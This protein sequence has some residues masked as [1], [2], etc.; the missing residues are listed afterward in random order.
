MPSQGGSGSL[1]ANFSVVNA[2]VA[3]TASPEEAAA[4]QAMLAYLLSR[5][6]TLQLFLL[7][8]YG[9]MCLLCIILVIY[10]R[11]NRNTA[12]R[13]DATA[14]RKIIL[15][16]Y[17]PLLWV[18]G[19][20]TGIYTG[21]FCSALATELYTYE[22]S[23][24]A[25]EVFYSGRQFVFLSV[26]VFMLQKSVSGPA[27]RR[28]LII[29][30]VLS[31]YTIPLVW[32]FTAYYPAAD[33][34]APLTAARALLLL[35]YSYVLVRPPVRASKRT[36][37][38]YCV[39]A[40]I[41]YTL[42]F[43]YNECF[44]QSHL[45]S[46]FYLTYSNLLCGSL[47][48]LVIWRVL[49]ADTEHWRGM[50]QRA[51][52]LQRLFCQTRG[53]PER[54]SSK[55]LHILIEMHRKFIIDFAYLE[56]QQR[57]GVGAS[58]V[59]FKGTL[60]SSIDVAV[61]V[62]TPTDFT[63]DTVA[64]FSHEAALC[65]ALHHPNIVAFHGMCVCPP[66]ICL[67]NELCVGSLEDITVAAARRRS[68]VSEHDHN[69]Q[70][71]LLNVAFMLDAARAVSYLHS[72][73]PPFL[74]RDIKPTNF[75]VDANC[76]VKLTDFGESRSLPRAQ[77]VSNGLV[78]APVTTHRSSLSGY[79]GEKVSTVAMLASEDSSAKVPTE[80]ASIEIAVVGAANLQQ[81]RGSLVDASKPTT[82][83][84]SDDNA[85]RMTVKG[86]VDYMAPEVINGRAGL[87]AYGEA[88][89]VYS[90]GITMWDVLNPGQ[91]KFPDAGSNHF[92]V[93][94]LVL[95]G[96]RPEL[97]P[98]LHPSIRAI[99]E[100]SWQHDPRLRPS[101]H[102]VVSTLESIQE[103]LSAAFALELA[104]E[105][106]DAMRLAK[107][108]DASSAPLAAPQGF[109]GEEAISHMCELQYVDS[110]SEAV[111]LGNALMDSGLLHHCKHAHP[112]EE[113]EQVYF[114]D[115]DNINL[116]Q[117]LVVGAYTQEQAKKLDAESATVISSPSRH[118]R[119]TSHRSGSTNPFANSG[120]VRSDSS[121]SQSDRTL[122]ENGVCACRKLGQRL[123][124]PK[125][126]K[127]RHRFRR[128]GKGK[129]GMKVSVVAGDAAE[130]LH[131]RLLLES[132]HDMH[133]FDGF[134][135]SPS[136]A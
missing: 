17:E 34:Y 128:K 103:E 54:V 15:P 14:A 98:R 30:L 134:D 104:D 20:T 33:L 80:R 127:S 52:A 44:R 40:Y 11:F 111:R 126:S 31:T 71:L 88:A 35:L 49:R 36:L 26:I 50:G 95:E 133:D 85:V 110:I 27:L 81:L 65:G 67:V 3:P 105:L 72:F 29:T 115:D 48:P 51:V 132:P 24:L 93:F 82:K 84:S 99:I 10:L 69:R 53:M 113:S 106:E 47:C 4:K 25:T 129:T 64:A 38:E 79:C 120:R 12:L 77:V 125:A 74:H 61:K 94:D 123:K 68:R 62:Y 121:Q 23:K 122:L 56:L 92:R 21:F 124:L 13:G 97:D 43:A 6:H 1:F 131:T 109:S 45:E 130:Q 66:T 91:E 107:P 58:A 101:A 16:A 102:S 90:L 28:T 9:I 22:I 7:L 114:F 46:G 87:A 78:S 55:G 42:L 86:T 8:G 100:S 76:S 32:V 136:P 83:E 116:C 96:Q 63:E 37:R 89:D 18:L 2:T 59:V 41:Y 118:S 117:P 57:I 135:G 73:R 119:R 5:F 39:F 75:L 112:F 60:R 108:I 70:Q 19:C